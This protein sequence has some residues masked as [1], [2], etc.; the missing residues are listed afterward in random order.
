MVWSKD[1]KKKYQ[2]RIGKTVIIPFV[3]WT[4]AKF[5]S[6]AL[7]AAP[8]GPAQTGR[9]QRPGCHHILPDVADWK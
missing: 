4:S 5:S 3:A 1:E 8:P 9:N 6:A 2:P 7:P